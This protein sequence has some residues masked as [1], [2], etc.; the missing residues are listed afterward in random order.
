MKK[1][2]KNILKWF[3][4]GVGIFCIMAG[5]NNLPRLKEEPIVVLMMFFLGY[6]LA[7]DKFK[8]IWKKLQEKS[9]LRNIKKSR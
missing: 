1:T 3:S 5:I 9:L 7:S 2:I 4:F 8:E 6:L